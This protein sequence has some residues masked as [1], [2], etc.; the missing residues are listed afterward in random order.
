[1]EREGGMEDG[2]GGWRM[3]NGE[4]EDGDWRVEIGEWRLGR[5]GRAPLV[6]GDC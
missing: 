2:D 6:A 1:M 5:R 3:E 4:M